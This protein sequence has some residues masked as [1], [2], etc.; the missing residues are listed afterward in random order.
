MDA[1]GFSALVPLFPDRTVITYDPRGLARSTRKDGQVDNRPEV[2]ASDLHAL[3]EA[4]G[5]ILR[6]RLWKVMRFG[7]DEGGGILCCTTC[8]GDH[9]PI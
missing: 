6:T 8:I 5:A 3:I 7:M 2:Q 4:L 9:N 1:S